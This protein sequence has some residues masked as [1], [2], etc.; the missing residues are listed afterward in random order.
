VAEFGWFRELNPA[1]R[2]DRTTVP[3]VATWSLPTRVLVGP[4]RLND[5]DALLEQHRINRPLIVTDSGLADS[6]MVAR[7]IGLAGSSGRTAEVFDRVRPDPSLEDVIAGAAAARGCDGIVS[8]GGGSAL[9]AA[10]LI[11]LA[12]GQTDPIWAF[13]DGATPDLS[14]IP[15]DLA[16]IIAIPT[17]AGTGSEVGRSGVLTDSDR[18][19]RVIFHPALLA[20][21]VICDPELTVALPRSLTV[22]TGFDALSH[23]LEAYCAPGYHPIA[24]GIAIEAIALVLGALPVVVAQ[25]DDL[26]ARQQMMVAALMSAT[27][28][29]KGLGAMHSI[30]HPLG[31]WFGTHHGTTNAVLMPYVLE[32]NRTA[33]EGRIEWLMSSLGLEGGFDRF[34]SIILE[35]RLELGV[36]HTLADLGIPP[37]ALKVVERDAPNDPTA[38][39]NPVP[40][41]AEYVAAVFGHAL[42]GERDTV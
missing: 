28:F 9:D 31:A 34:L 18:I 32:A 17:T 20:T 21:A 23:A 29:Q 8:I 16:P 1:V 5:L 11:A 39:T 33:I 36:P 10:K 42:S 22:G 37:D 14:R 35:L 12:A 15:L 2:P 19:K 13:I 27:A 26:A 40:V 25:P 4:G 7:V 24:D 30:S 6:A 38:A 41:T 3:P